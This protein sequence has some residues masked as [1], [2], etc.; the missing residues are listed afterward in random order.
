MLWI[1]NIFS[2][3]SLVNI[4]QFHTLVKKQQHLNKPTF[5]CWI[6]LIFKVWNNTEN[7]KVECWL[8]ACNN[9]YEAEHVAKVRL[10]RRGVGG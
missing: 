7:L 6:Y 2:S 10:Y 9:I 8:L 3:P 1:F 4:F 5:W